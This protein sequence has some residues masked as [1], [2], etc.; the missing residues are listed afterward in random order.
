M[1]LGL[2]AGGRLSCDG[3]GHRQAP[4]RCH[5]PF[6]SGQG[7]VTGGCLRRADRPGH[8]ASGWLRRV[9][10]QPNRCQAG[11][12]GR[13]GSQSDSRANRR[14]RSDR[15]TTSSRTGS[16]RGSRSSTTG[17]N[18]CRSISIVWWRCAHRGRCC[19]PTGGRI[20]GSILQASS[21]C[22]ARPRR[23]IGSWAPGISAATALPPDGILIDGTLGYFLRPGGHSLKPEDWKA[24]LDFADKQLGSPAKPRSVSAPAGTAVRRCHAG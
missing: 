8:S 22:C 1:G 5:R 16:T 15:S 24:F 7:R 12:A 3:P 9:G 23:S 20:P 2:A 6:A 17:R 14:K 11:G 18:V 10:T 21:R 13:L 19:S 4:H